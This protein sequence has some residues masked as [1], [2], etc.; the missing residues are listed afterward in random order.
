MKSHLSL[1]NINFGY[2]EKTL[3]FSNLTY[4]L[5]SG[6]IVSIIGN[7]GCGKTTLLNLVAGLLTPQNGTI[8]TTN[9]AYLTQK[10]TL[11]SY[12]TAFENALFAC[13]LR[14][15]LTETQIEE[16]H[17][18]FQQFNLP[19]NAKAKFPQELSGGMQQRVALI[20]MLLIDAELYL[21]D[22]P[23]NAIDRTTSLSI[24]EF[25]WDRFK[26]NRL[27]LIIV[28]HDL[29]EAVL[30]SDKV[31]I[32]SAEKENQEIVFDNKFSKL[33]PQER[34]NTEYYNQYMLEII[35]KQKHS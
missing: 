9:N 7:S 22:E 15:N 24:Q 4:E 18:L 5:K 1:N 31:L 19:E 29:E 8:S 35:E 3:I 23:F 21:L 32:L 13:E 25:I 27:S 6:E 14:N 33:N 28:T 12:R 10:V 2:D 20:Q 34:L 16:A 17:K 11:F 30:L 26:S